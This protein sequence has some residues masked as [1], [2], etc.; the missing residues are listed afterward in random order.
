VC[1]SSVFLSRLKS[2]SV[3]DDWND[4]AAGPRVN[5]DEFYALGYWVTKFC[6]TEAQL[7]AAV[8]AAGDVPADVEKFLRGDE[9]V[10]PAPVSG[11]K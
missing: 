3:Q 10:D 1:R 9:S 6:C 8:L 4:P 11:L 5:V 2:K 7:R